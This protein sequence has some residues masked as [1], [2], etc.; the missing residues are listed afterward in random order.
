MKALGPILYVAS[1]VCLVTGCWLAATLK[2]TFT[3]SPLRSGVSDP[4]GAS[5]YSGSST[6]R[7]CHRHFYDL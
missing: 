6:C 3:S 7:D 4:R 5:G 2:P 1:G